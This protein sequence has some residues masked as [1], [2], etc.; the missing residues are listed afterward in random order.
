MTVENVNAFKPPFVKI[1]TICDRVSKKLGVVFKNYCDGNNDIGTIFFPFVEELDEVF[2][3]E[4]E[5]LV[6][7]I[8]EKL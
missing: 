2:A 7:R 6:D 4:A 5:K 1:K 3:D 8:N